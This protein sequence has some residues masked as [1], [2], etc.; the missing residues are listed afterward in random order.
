MIWEITQDVIGDR[1]PLLDVIGAHMVPTGVAVEP[2]S[3]LR[4]TGFHVFNNYPNP[5]N[6]STTIQYVMP[7]SSHVTV[8]IF[9]VL[10]REV[11]TLVDG[12]RTSGINTVRF[13]ASRYNIPSGVYFYRIEAGRFA[14]TRKMSFVK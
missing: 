13:D 5:F 9:D 10:G 4:P 7:A 12:Y 6:P 14:E 2:R 11:A 8:K 1:Q 3:G